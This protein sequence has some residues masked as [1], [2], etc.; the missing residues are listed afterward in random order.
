MT[1][2]DKA[3]KEK[4]MKT[5]KGMADEQAQFEKQT[6]CAECGSYSWSVRE[7]EPYCDKGRPITKGMKECNVSKEKEKCHY[8]LSDDFKEEVGEFKVMIEG[9]MKRVHK[10]CYNRYLKGESNIRIVIK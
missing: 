1:E 2:A 6:I 7:S 9:K 4:I 3:I 8:C 5:R 10:E